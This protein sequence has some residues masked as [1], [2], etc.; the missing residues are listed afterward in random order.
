MVV[1]NNDVTPGVNKKLIPKY[2][3]PYTIHKILPNDRYAIKDIERFQV[4]QIPFEGIFDSLSLR[5]WTE[6]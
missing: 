3:G 6:N 5:K 4:T 2:K 1:T